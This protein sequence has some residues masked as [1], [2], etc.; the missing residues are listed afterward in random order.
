MALI[1]LMW[2]MIYMGQQFLIWFGFKVHTPRGTLTNNLD[3]FRIC[4]VVC[5]PSYAKI[6]NHIDVFT[7]DSTVWSPVYV[8]SACIGCESIS[9]IFSHIESYSFL[10]MWYVPIRCIFLSW[11]GTALLARMICVSMYS[12]RKQIRCIFIYLIVPTP[13]N[14]VGT[15]IVHAFSLRI[16]YADCTD[17]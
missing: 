7:W 14:V 4:S 10:G 1:P 8:R 13:W 11:D 2:L 12:S 16:Y 5:A 17:N 15:N 6:I 3:I 9:D